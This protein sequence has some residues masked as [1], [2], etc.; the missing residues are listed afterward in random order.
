ERLM[1][2]LSGLPC[3]INVLMFNSFPGAAFERPDDERAYAFRNILLNHGFVAVVRNS[4][5]GDINAACGQLR[6]TAR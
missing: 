1:E 4:K 3:M 6:A 5:G 2:L